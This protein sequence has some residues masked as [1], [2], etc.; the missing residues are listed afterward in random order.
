MIEVV[1]LK[2]GAIFKQAFGQPETFTQFV[3]DVLDINIHIDKV[4]AEYE[5]P[6]PVGFVRSKYDLFAEDI[7][8]RIVVEIQHI[9]EED[10]FDRFLYYHLV[11]LVEQIGSFQEYN[12]ERTVYTIVV[13]TS[14]PR[15]GSVDFSCAVSDMNPTDERGRKLSIYP[16]RLVFLCPRLVNDKTPPKIKRWLELIEDS[17]D[18]KLEENNYSEKM[19]QAILDIIRKL[20]IDRD[21]LAQIKDEAAWEKAKQRFKEEGMEEGLQ[22]GK[23]EGDKQ[24]RLETARAMLADGMLVETVLRYTGLTATDLSA[25]H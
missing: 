20:N 10:F 3:N 18:G 16:H 8:Q 22:I 6:N 15:D 9:K 24:A 23:E 25:L 17:L 12:F 5:Y 19:F 14:V 4:H 7:E 2:Y 11:S 21:M 1:P 13:L